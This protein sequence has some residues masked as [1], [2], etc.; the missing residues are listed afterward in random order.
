MK[1]TVTKEMEFNDFMRATE[2]NHFLENVPPEASIRFKHN[3]GDRPFDP[4][5]NTITAR[6]EAE[7]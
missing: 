6:W 2:L 5:T 3:P 7:L 4:S 1:T